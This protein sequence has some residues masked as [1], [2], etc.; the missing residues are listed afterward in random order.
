MVEPADLSTLL[1]RAR[2]SASARRQI[3]CCPEQFLESVLLA[4]GNAEAADVVARELDGRPVLTEQPRH[5]A[6]ATALTR[7]LSRLP[8]GDGSAALD[9]LLKGLL[10]DDSPI[11]PEL[12]RNVRLRLP[13]RCRAASQ[14]QRER[15]DWHGGV[16]AATTPSPYLRP[17]RLQPASAPLVGRG[18]VVAEVLESVAA[19]HVVVV[20]ADGTGRRSVLAMALRR[21]RDGRAPTALAGR[22]LFALDVDCL[23]AGTR[24][25]ARLDD[26][27]RQL[28]AR[29][30]GSTRPPVVLADDLDALVDVGDALLPALKLGAFH[31]VGQATRAQACAW[32]AAAPDFAAVLAPVS[33]PA[34]SARETEALLAGWLSH[35]TRCS[36]AR[37]AP[38]AVHDAI[39]ICREQWPDAPLPGA[40]AVLL[41]EAAAMH[42]HEV[43]SPTIGAAHLALAAI[44]RRGRSSG[45]LT[46][47]AAG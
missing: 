47:G 21:L 24:Y 34:A 11:S 37:F 17:W 39:A 43:S 22:T 23:I 40:A 38:N 27:L 36:G 45:T 35:W 14:P 2:A 3:V 29:L 13:E 7:W 42:G 6:D 8:A 1:A 9:T 41:A 20:G 31:L 32:A 25:R 18:D 4:G 33:L 12:R 5:V 16:S 15:F 44:R 30:G 28:A 46:P 26:E 10:A 19:G